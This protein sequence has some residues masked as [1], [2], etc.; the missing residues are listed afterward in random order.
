MTAGHEWVG[1]SDILFYQQFGTLDILHLT[2]AGG[3]MLFRLY[4]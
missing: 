2:W 4:F 1:N 3:S